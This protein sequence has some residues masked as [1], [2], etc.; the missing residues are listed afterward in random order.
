M[1]NKQRREYKQANQERKQ[2]M[3]ERVKNCD[4]AMKDYFAG[5]GLIQ[6]GK[7]TK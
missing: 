2:R 6:D 3:I 7:H 5:F 1:T 4:K